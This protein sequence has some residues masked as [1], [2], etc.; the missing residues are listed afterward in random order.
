MDTKQQDELDTKQE[1]SEEKKNRLLEAYKLHAQLASDMSNR[2][3]T[4]DRFYPTLISGLLVIFLTVLQHKS[5]ILPQKIEGNPLTAYSTLITGY[6]GVLLSLMW[7]YSI[8]QYDLMLNRKYKFLIELETKLEFHFFQQ[9]W[10]SADFSKF[11]K[12]ETY[13]PR[14]FLFLFILLSILGI[15]LSLGRA[16]YI[17]K[18]IFN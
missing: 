1:I 12:A 4:T 3:A 16:K 7:M 8:N 5:N 11:S 13:I 18:S 6:L 2:K 15:L 10:K 9:E 17:L 14:A